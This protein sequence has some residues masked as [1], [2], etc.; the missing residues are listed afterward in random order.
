M[1]HALFKSLDIP[2]TKS[3]FKNLNVE[4][5]KLP[6][7]VL[8]RC[9]TPALIL[10]KDSLVRNVRKIL[11]HC[12]NDPKRWRPHL[13]TTKSGVL[14]K[15]LIQEGGITQFKV[16]TT[17]EAELIATSIRDTGAEGGDVL[18]AYPLQGPNMKRLEA[19]AN[20]FSETKFSV[21]VESEC[22]A[23]SVPSSLDCFVDINVG[24]NRTG[25]SLE[26]AEKGA[27]VDVVDTILKTGRRFRGLHLYDGHSQNF[28]DG[29]DRN[30]QV[31]SVGE[32]GTRLMNLLSQAGHNVEEIITA[33]TPSL[34]SALKFINSLDGND[35]HDHDVRRA[36]SPGTVV[37]HDLTS[38][39]SNEELDLE[40]ACAVLSRVSVV[41]GGL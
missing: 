15:M 17:R 8:E 28:H 20:E 21:L 32:A 5:F 40:P 27:V 33:G 37:L 18:V 1:R 29:E 26:K 11:K 38:E 39:V 16:A 6:D 2:L 3:R 7:D 19:I 22:G 30:A 34:L 12:D 10:Y 23:R 13:K 24:Q 9:M 4:K 41:F 36:V 25:M 31:R 35:D 14:Y